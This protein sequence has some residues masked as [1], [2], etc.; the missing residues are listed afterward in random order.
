VA[1]VSPPTSSERE[2]SYRSTEPAS[3]KGYR[4]VAMEG[5]IARWYARTRGTP[6]Q[7]AAWVRQADELTRDL[8][9]HA[10]V[11]EVAPGP[12]YFS[13]ELARSGRVHVTALEISR[14]FIKI[15]TAYARRAGVDVTIREGDA[16]RM[17]FPADSFDLVVCQAAFKNFSRPQAAVNE[18]CRVLRP[19]GSARIQDMRHDASDGA[20]RTEV[21]AM[22]LGAVRSFMTR[23]ALASLRRRAYSRAQF[24]RFAR[25]SPF[26]SCT[27]AE[28]PL[29][30]DVHLTRAPPPR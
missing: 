12:G 27:I 9:D 14:T 4:G 25:T 17:P 13:V 24:E 8:P 20:I 26:G 19:G 7:I 15:A 28:D 5:S 6:D 10:R 30:F 1:A 16:S 22:G 29:G 11:L 2:R 18:M 21:A 3:S 23:R